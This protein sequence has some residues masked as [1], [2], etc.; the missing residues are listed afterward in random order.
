MPGGVILTA[1]KNERFGQ[2]LQIRLDLNAVI[3]HSVSAGN[4]VSKRQLSYFLKE[5]GW[6]FAFLL[7]NLNTMDSVEREGV[8]I[9][10]IWV[11]L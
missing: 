7:M 2:G 8:R 1:E 4:S 9:S 5:E 6:L 11:L 10:P 3:T